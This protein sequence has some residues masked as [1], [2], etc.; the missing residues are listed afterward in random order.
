MMRNPIFDLENGGSTYARGR[1]IHEE[2]RQLKNFD[3]IW[4]WV[5]DQWSG[6]GMA[7][8]LLE[9]ANYIIMSISVFIWTTKR[10]V[11]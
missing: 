8:N 6:E 4:N 10:N 11:T 7:S 2:V 9:Y 1:L 5:A 3:K